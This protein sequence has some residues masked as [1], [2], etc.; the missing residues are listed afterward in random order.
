MCSW[1]P[2]ALGLRHGRSESHRP[3]HVQEEELRESKLCSPQ[4][5]QEWQGDLQ[6]VVSESSKSLAK[7]HAHGSHHDWRG[8]P[9]EAM[10]LACVKRAGATSHSCWYAP[11]QLIELRTVD[12]S[13][14]GTG[15]RVLLP[16]SSY[17]LNHVHLQ[18]GS[19]AE[20]SKAHM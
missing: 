4:A 18:H 14:G 13:L 15:C 10:H 16:T 8:D 9:H 20:Q 11:A 19:K 3:P 5:D 2:V 7:L 1:N 12:V 17:L 6:L